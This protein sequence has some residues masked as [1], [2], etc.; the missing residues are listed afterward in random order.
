[1]NTAIQTIFDQIEANNVI[2]RGFSKK[3]DIIQ[4]QL[5]ICQ[6]HLKNHLDTF[7][8]H[9]DRDKSDLSF[10]ECQ[11]YSAAAEFMA[12]FGRTNN[13]VVE[14]EEHLNNMPV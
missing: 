11:D 2:I 12:R 1:M 10:E 14:V 4:A 6:A 8:A 13:R 5:N 7:E 3:F 9:F